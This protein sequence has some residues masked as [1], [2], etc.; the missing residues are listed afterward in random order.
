MTEQ[1]FDATVEQGIVVL[2]FWANWC[3]PCRAFA[4]V[5]EAAAQ[6]HPDVVF[7]KVDTEAERGLAATFDIRSIPS[8]MVIRDGV[9]LAT[10][11][12]ARPAASLDA[13]IGKVRDLDMEDVRR[14]LD[15]H[16]ADAWVAKTGAA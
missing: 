11:P 5:F 6:R 4:P 16:T 3:G 9:L 8:L 2:D 13:I 7:G 14:E 10:L 1:N 15:A 12:G